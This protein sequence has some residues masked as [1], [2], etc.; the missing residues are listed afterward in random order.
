M[1]TA[2]DPFFLRELERLGPDNP[3]QAWE[4]SAAEAY[5][6]T[7][8]SQ[9]Y[10]NFS[11]VSFLLPRRLRQDFYNIYSYCRWS[12][13]L[14]DEV[15]STEKSLQLL[16]WWS[17]QLQL[18]YSGRPAHPVMVALQNTVQ[19]YNIPQQPF[20][21]LLSAFRQDQQIRRYDDEASLLDYCQ[22]SANPVGRILLYLAE[23]PELLQE[24]NLS[25]SDLI[26]TGLQLANFCQDM[27][28]D[29]AIDRIYL[30]RSRWENASEQDFLSA[31][32]TA[33]LC[34]ILEKW[35]QCTREYFVEGSALIERV[36]RWLAVDIELF[37]SGGLEILRQIE[38][39][40]FD[41]WT[42][43]PVVSK[44][45]KFKLLL[46]ALTRRTFSFGKAKHG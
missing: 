45:S 30:P 39:A 28:R 46:R 6:K 15:E 34:R 33:E 19:Q 44:L 9:Q 4:L 8:A 7:W 20:Q 1:T 41:V 21:D 29:A 24:E 12:D 42:Q 37:V 13:N 40:K 22:R 36:P 3:P 43:R 11:V 2:G 27:A 31:R 18:C 14:A 17:A 10:E 26:C 16:D 32:P 25:L 38:H 35:V 23:D 5:C